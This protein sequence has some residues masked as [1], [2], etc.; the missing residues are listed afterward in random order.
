M[1]SQHIRKYLEKVNE[2]EEV[3]VAV[4]GLKIIGSNILTAIIIILLGLIIGQTVSAFIY[5]TILILLR[6]M[7]N[8]KN[9]LLCILG[10][11]ILSLANNPMFQYA[12]QGLFPG[13]YA[14]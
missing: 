3:E 11:F 10:S 8:N 14:G 2:P 5:L 6:K 12:K 13:G 1:E 9:I 7:K 4:Y